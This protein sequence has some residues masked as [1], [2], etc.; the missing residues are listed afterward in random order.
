MSDAQPP[1]DNETVSLKVSQLDAGS[2]LDGYLAAHI[3]GWSRAR[4]QR[5]I[6]AGD[7]LVNSKVAKASYKVSTN[8]EIEVELT[9]PPAANFT[10]ENIALDI[11][12]EDDHLVVINKPAGLVVH[13][14]AGVYS[15]TLANALAYHF[16]QLSRAG[17]IRPGI[18]HRLDKDTSGLL[19]VAKTE[20]AHESLADQF[21]AREVFKSYVALVYGVVKQESG[22]IEQSIA[23]DPRNRT[24]MAVVAGGRGALS[25]YK[26]RR[27]Y[28]EFT[29]L[30]V[31]LKTGRTHQIRVHLAWLKHPV[32]GD[33]LYAGGRENSVQDVQL[34]ARIRKL[35]RQFLHAEQLGFRHPQ[36]NEQLRFVAPL[37]DELTQ[38]LAALE[39]R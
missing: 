1:P 34:R 32:V 3:D 23:R 12:F 30:D 10:P 33:E 37:P 6:E 17:S 29:L 15:G 7:V 5:L 18:V 9:P 36:T 22:R 16:Q 2:R 19:V 13:P 11:I 39:A 31:E 8:D 25:L 28:K 26:V 20:S 4:L 14:A 27:S 38:L 24:R 35:G 21:R